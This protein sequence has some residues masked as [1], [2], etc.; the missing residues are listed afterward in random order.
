MVT[1]LYSRFSLFL[2]S[3]LLSPALFSLRFVMLSMQLVFGWN[4]FWYQVGS[5]Y[6]VL[7]NA[8]LKIIFISNHT[9][10]TMLVKYC[11]KIQMF[12]IYYTIYYYSL[13]SLVYILYRRYWFKTWIKSLTRNNKLSTCNKF[14]TLFVYLFVFIKILAD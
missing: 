3:I 2:L 6:T 5:C 8:L 4:L 12:I 9:W 7:L 10:L 1:K 14:Q 13:F 11:Y